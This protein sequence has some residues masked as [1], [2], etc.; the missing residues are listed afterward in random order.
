[1]NFQAFLFQSNPVDQIYFPHLSH[2][3]FETEKSNCAPFELNA[4]QF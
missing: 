4:I 3:K 1:M 2:L